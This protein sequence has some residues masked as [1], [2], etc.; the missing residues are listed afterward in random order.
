M[1]ETEVTA[2]SIIFLNLMIKI[3]INFNSNKGF[4]EN[5]AVFKKISQIGWKIP[6][7]GAYLANFGDF[8]G[9]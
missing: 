2:R 9:S 7:F 1:H 3:I 4:S 6:I 8:F 5:I